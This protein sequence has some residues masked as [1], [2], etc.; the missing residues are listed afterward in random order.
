M[1]GADESFA[2]SDTESVHKGCLCSVHAQ[3]TVIGTYHPHAHDVGDRS[4]IPGAATTTPT[5]GAASNALYTRR[6]LRR[7]TTPLTYSRSPRTE[8]RN[9][10]PSGSTRSA[11][12]RC[13]ATDCA[14]RS[15]SASVT[16]SRSGNVNT[17]VWQPQ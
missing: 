6:A 17:A 1:K 9:R 7:L 4:P 13:S 5:S 10:S 15:T 11:H 12:V 14:S 8:S 2:P 16:G 3:I